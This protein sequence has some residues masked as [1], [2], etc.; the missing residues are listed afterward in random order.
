MVED[1]NAAVNEILSFM[2]DNQKS[3]VTEWKCARDGVHV[4]TKVC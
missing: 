1:S 4:Q 2:Q 3:E